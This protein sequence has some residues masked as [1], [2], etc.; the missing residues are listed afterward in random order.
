MTTFSD[1]NFEALRVAA[2]V[3][4]KSESWPRPNFAEASIKGDKPTLG[5]ADGPLHWNHLH[6]CVSDL[7]T[8]TLKVLGA[9]SG[10]DGN[11]SLSVD[12]RR[13]Q[14]QKAAQAALADLEKSPAL[15]KARAAVEQQV[16]LWD[17]EL[18]PPPVDP[19]IAQEIRAHVARL[20]DGERL[21]FVT[22]NIAEAGP[23]VLLGPSF[24]SGL[25]PAEQDIVRKQFEVRT[26]PEASEA[27]RKTLDAAAHTEAG[28]RNAV[29]TIRERAGLD[30]VPSN[31][32]T[33]A[34]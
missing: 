32:G 33:A 1:E 14:K 29:R 11:K 28:F 34:A 9:F 20:R 8:R 13:E 27:K 26:N 10:I 2:S 18:A 6:D 17:K 21:V 22:R 3:A 25:T 7:R 4:P 15:A 31:G 19:T 30:A 5:S 12:G 23:A 24:L 16:K